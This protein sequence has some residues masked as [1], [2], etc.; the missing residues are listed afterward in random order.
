VSRRWVIVSFKQQV[1]AL[2]QRK[3]SPMSQPS[4]TTV[5]GVEMDVIKP[6]MEDSLLGEDQAIVKNLKTLSLQ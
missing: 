1:F 5:A 6:R 4:R 3:F 2:K